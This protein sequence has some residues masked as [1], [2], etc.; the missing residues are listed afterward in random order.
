MV[1]NSDSHQLYG[2]HG[3]Y[4]HAISRPTPEYLEDRQSD[5]KYVQACAISAV[6]RNGTGGGVYLNGVPVPDKFPVRLRRG[7]VL[8]L[9]VP[10]SGGMY[11]PAS[12]NREALA[13]DIADGLVT[14][15]A[16]V[17]DY[18]HAPTLEHAAE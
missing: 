1:Q 13:R 8:Q 14:P 12:R 6:G 3:R 4:W 9:Q 5:Y 18:G 16:A 10:G 7:D 15:E 2:P 11:P 17:R